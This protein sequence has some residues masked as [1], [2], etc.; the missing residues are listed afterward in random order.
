[1]EQAQQ[2]SPEEPSDDDD[3]AAGAAA[4]AGLL[5]DTVAA[6]VS[7]MLVLC[8]DAAAAGVVAAAAENLVLGVVVVVLVGVAVVGVAGEPPASVPLLRRR[9]MAANPVPLDAGGSADGEALTAGDAEKPP[10][11]EMP[12]RALPLPPNVAMRSRSDFGSATACGVVLPPPT[13]PPPAAP[14][15]PARLP[16]DGAVGALVLLPPSASRAWRRTS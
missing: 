11:R 14:P 16:V 3:D 1:M 15:A 12:G 6:R 10:A 4:A 8:G 5:V 2:R 13:R 7:R 9:P